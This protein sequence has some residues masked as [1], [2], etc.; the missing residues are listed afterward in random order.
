VTR[1]IMLLTV[2]RATLPQLQCFVV[3]PPHAPVSCSLAV[4]F[5]VTRRFL[6]TNGSGLDEYLKTAGQGK[7]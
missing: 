2:A 7:A 4:S 1:L 3:A 5:L 6:T